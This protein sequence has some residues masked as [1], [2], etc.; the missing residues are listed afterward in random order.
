[1]TPA[2]PAPAPAQKKSGAPV[3]IIILA[4]LG[5]GCVVFGILAAIAIPNFIRF[6]ARSK[7]TECKANLKAIYV[8]EKAFFEDSK[9][10]SSS[11]KE[12][13]FD[14]M[15]PHQRY[16]YFLTETEVLPAKEPDAIGAASALQQLQER[17]VTVGA[18]DTGFTA[19]CIGNIDSDPTQDMW[20][21]SSDER[22]DKFG[23]HVSAG[24]VHQDSDDIRRD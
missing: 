14:P 5:G 23:A 20:S 3:V 8:A 13:G 6:Q 21:I 16:S 24:E 17:G 1:M 22:T 9:K 12:I 18:T 19:A 4:V 2:P 7:Q 15:T 10:Y 11:F